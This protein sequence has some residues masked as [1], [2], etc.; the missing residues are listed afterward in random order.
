MSHG[1][2]IEVGRVVVVYRPQV[3]YKF[4]ASHRLWHVD[5]LPEPY[6]TVHVGHAPFREFGR[7][8]HGLPAALVE[9]WRCPGRLVALYSLVFRA[10]F[11]TPLLQLACE[12]RLQGRG[13][14]R[15]S[16]HLIY[17]RGKV[18]HLPKCLAACPGL[19]HGA[20]PAEIG[21]ASCRERV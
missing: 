21:R 12:L 10:H 7:Y 15:H 20:S 6:H 9:H 11:V 17:C 13:I 14:G 18:W 5:S 8:G 4:L 16:L 2:T 3:E 19:C 1:L